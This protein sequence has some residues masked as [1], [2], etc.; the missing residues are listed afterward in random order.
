MV[1]TCAASGG[2]D[3]AYDD[4]DFD[5]AL[6]MS[7]PPKGTELGEEDAG[8]GEA[9]DRT[10]LHQKDR[11]NFILV[12]AQDLQARGIMGRQ[13][14]VRATRCEGK[15]ECLVV[16]TGTLIWDPLVPGTLR[17]HYT[18]SDYCVRLQSSCDSHSAYWVFSV[19]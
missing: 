18:S 9:S 15:T 19:Q 16:R 10:L 7:P 1:K 11:G 12:A 17:L 4:G 13:H 8:A 5:A 14:K 6:L 3:V 2:P